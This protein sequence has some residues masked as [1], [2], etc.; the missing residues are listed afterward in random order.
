MAIVTNNRTLIRLAW[1]FKFLFIEQARVGDDCTSYFRI[2]F[3]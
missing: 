1:P 2:S 3:R